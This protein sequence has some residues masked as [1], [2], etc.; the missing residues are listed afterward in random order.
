MHGQAE[1]RVMVCAECGRSARWEGW[2]KALV[3][4]WA[5]EWK[6]AALVFLCPEQHETP[7]PKVRSGHRVIKKKPEAA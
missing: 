7:A 1:R 3:A 6:R 2:I 4:G 5:W